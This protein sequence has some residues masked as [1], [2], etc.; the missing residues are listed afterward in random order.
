MKRGKKNIL[1]DHLTRLYFI[2]NELK[3]S[4]LQS[5]IQN[6][7]TKPIIRG[8]ALYKKTLFSRKTSISNQNNVCL[9][10]GRIRGV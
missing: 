6:K 4:I 7:N 1:K 3:N 8:F 5:I 9:I 10:R 2:K